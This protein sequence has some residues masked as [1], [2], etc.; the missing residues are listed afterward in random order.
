MNLDNFITE[1]ELLYASYLEDE[2]SKND[3]IVGIKRLIDN[4]RGSDKSNVLQPIIHSQPTDGFNYWIRQ[5][6][7][8][9]WKVAEARH[10][11]IYNRIMLFTT[12]GARVDP[13]YCD[14]RANPLPIPK[15]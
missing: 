9:K 14:W 13:K 10:C 11:R 1:I 5:D 8:H 2:C 4:E 15:G 12:N 3:V 6:E 7:K